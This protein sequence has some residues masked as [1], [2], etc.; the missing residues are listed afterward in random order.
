MLNGMRKKIV[1]AFTYVFEM[2]KPIIKRKLDNIIAVCI[3]HTG[4]MEG[5]FSISTSCELN[6]H[7]QARSK[8]KGSICE[9]CFAFA[10]FKMRPSMRAR[11]RHNTEL[12]TSSVLPFDV[13]PILN[14]LYFRF[15][16][17]GD[18]NN[19]IQVKNYFNI[20][21]KNPRTTFALWTKN[22]FY[23]ANAIRD[24]YKKPE[25]LIVL[26]SSPMIDANVDTKTLLRVFPFIDK[27][28]TVYSDEKTAAAH[29]RTINCGTRVCLDCL[30]C[31]THNNDTEVSELL[32]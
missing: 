10:N 6:K 21:Y 24:G 32:K 25:N 31:Y 3:E 20:C 26:Y 17:F 12:L 4:K 30:R 9:K 22:P 18:L 13:L 15:E 1:T 16:S 2:R 27:V 23:I 5:M 28:F 7:C 29:G 8:L 19:S 14:N 11:Y